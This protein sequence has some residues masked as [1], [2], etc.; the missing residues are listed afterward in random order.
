[1]EF[2]DG[3]EGFVSVVIFIFVIISAILIVGIIYCVFIVC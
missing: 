2:D 1:M 3:W